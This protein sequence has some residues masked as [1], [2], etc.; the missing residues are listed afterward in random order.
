MQSPS[1]FI[2]IGSLISGAASLTA[3]LKT[4]RSAKELDSKIYH[5]TTSDR[6]PNVQV[7]EI[8]NV[9]NHFFVTEDFKA[10]EGYASGLGFSAFRPGDS[11]SGMPVVLKVSVLDPTNSSWVRGWFGFQK[12]FR[13]GTQLRVDEVHT[14]PPLSDSVKKQI[15]CSRW[16]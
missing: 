5:G 15:E 13:H 16:T 1:N 8:L 7:G 14:P 12:Y 11:S 2:K 3:Y 6:M 4:P 9:R 10:A